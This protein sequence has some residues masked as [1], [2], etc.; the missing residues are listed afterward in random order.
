MGAR[1]RTGSERASAATLSTLPRA[2]PIAFQRTGT[3]GPRQQRRERPV[4]VDAAWGRLTSLA[5]HV[6]AADCEQ[7]MAALEDDTP[8]AM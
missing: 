8:S 3:C 1:D 5:E 2:T 7:D 4:A 6:R